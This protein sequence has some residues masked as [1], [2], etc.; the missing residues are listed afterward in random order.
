[1][2][3]AGN[4]KKPPASGKEEP[5]ERV[6]L[7]GKPTAPNAKTRFAKLGTGEAI[8][9]VGEPVVTAVDHSALDLLD[10]KLLAIDQ[11]SITSIQTTSVGNRVKL[12]RKEKQWQVDAAAAKFV[13]DQ[14]AITT[15]LTTWANLQ[16]ERFAAYG[17]K[18]D[19]AKFGL[20]KPA[21]TAT[22]TVA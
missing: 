3:E 10:R 14:E 9:V 1:K 15:L 13:A 5:K 16:A 2:K 18:L 4:D 21:G 22:V 8:F 11:K 20:D 6:L 12:E 7:I 19:L 17:P